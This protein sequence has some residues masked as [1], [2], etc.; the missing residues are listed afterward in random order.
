M[1]NALTQ[2]ALLEQQH[3]FFIGEDSRCYEWLGC[4]YAGDGGYTFRMWAPD[5]A[6]VS[7]VGDFGNWDTTVQP[8]GELFGGIW[9]C[10][11]QNVQAYSAYKYHILYN[12]G[13]AVEVTDP[14]ATCLST[15]VDGAGLV[16]DG[17]NYMWQDEGWRSPGCP[18]NI[19]EVHLASWRRYADGAPLSYA[20]L[21][22]ELIP[23]VRELG[24]THLRLLRFSEGVV[25]PPCHGEPHAF[26][27][28]VDT[29][30]R[31]G[32]GVLLDW[33]PPTEE[34]P[35]HQSM[36]LSRALYWLTQYHIDGLW[37][38]GETAT[39]PL[40]ARLFDLCPHA[41]LLRE[42]SGDSKPSS[43]CSLLVGMPGDYDQQLAGVRALLAY[44]LLSPGP[45]RLFMGD[46]FGQQKPW[47]PAG[48]L[49][50]LLLDYED[51]RML[52][53]YVSALN[54]LY[55]ETPALWAGAVW[56]AEDGVL[57]A[58]LGDGV[59]AVCN[60]TPFC[61]ENFRMGLPDIGDYTVLFHSDLKQF[62]GSIC[63]MP[64]VLPELIPSCG[65]AYSTL[66]TLPPL[67]AV[68]LRKL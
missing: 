60:T 41:L 50:W 59:T 52:H 19:Y 14:Y 12:D 34:T 3:A 29:C 22:E 10:T 28:F 43:A 13:Q 36:A 45:R 66:L 67:S 26:K 33:L 39:H 54:R 23:Y 64:A 1:H 40:W 32:L 47:D 44:R 20:A 21:Q 7:L 57:I 35:A 31:A 38:G 9:E 62:G 55:I 30:H 61:Q 8:M 15:G 56:M 51:N 6:A 4:H 65:C 63:H 68:L 42:P 11:L 27:K 53:H 24:F 46:E 16:Y 58:Y 18:P 17:D 2:D 37:A 49:D 25:P 48:S 5:A